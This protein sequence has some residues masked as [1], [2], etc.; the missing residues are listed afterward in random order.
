MWCR[1]VHS[2]RIYFGINKTKECNC[3]SN[4]EIKDSQQQWQEWRR[5][6]LSLVATWSGMTD[7]TRRASCVSKLAQVNI[8]TCP[9]L[10]LVLLYCFLQG[11][12]S[13]VLEL[14]DIFLRTLRHSVIIC[15]NFHILLFCVYLLSLQ[16]HQDYNWDMR[17]KTENAS[18]AT[19]LC[20][21]LRR[22]TET[23][24]TALNVKNKRRNWLQASSQ[25]VGWWQ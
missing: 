11:L 4:T 18:P 12:Q 17:I 13:M 22:L 2:E 15:Q 23:L 24:N 1:A 7:K 16:A 9:I 6:L 21:N 20:M 3:N 25:D 8:M 14:T 19:F 10:S 5:I